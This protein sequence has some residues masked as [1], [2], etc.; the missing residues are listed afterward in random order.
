M[1]ALGDRMTTPARPSTMGRTLNA[2]GALAVYASSPMKA[3]ARSSSTCN[4]RT[5]SSSF[6]IL[7]SIDQVDIPRVVEP[8]ND[9]GL[10]KRRGKVAGCARENSRGGSLNCTLR[11]F[12]NSKVEQE[13]LHDV[14]W[15]KLKAQVFKKYPPVVQNHHVIEELK[16]LG[17]WLQK[18]YDTC[19]AESFGN[20][21]VC[22]VDIKDRGAVENRLISSMRMTYLWKNSISPV[23]TRLCSPPETHM[24]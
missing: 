13:I 10:L 1:H 2:L 15:R 11:L 22:R 12:E 8:Q 18:E 6:P 21:A 3:S 19:F 7:R 20:A 23:I 24:Q 14:T 9:D 4:A 17:Q 16:H 5:N